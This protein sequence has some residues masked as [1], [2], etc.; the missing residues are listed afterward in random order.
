MRTVIKPFELV[1]PA[2]VDQAL[3]L[4]D[5]HKERAMIVAGGTDVVVQLVEKTLAPEIVIDI[6]SIK[7]L[8][9]I[10]EKDGAITIGALTTHTS[11]ERS[12][13]VKQK[14]PLLADAARDVGSAQIRNRGTIGGNLV[15]ASPAADTAPPLLALAAK[16][17]LLGAGGERV[18][19]IEEFFTGAR[20]SVI[21]RN[22]ILTEIQIPI[23]ANGRIGTRWLKVGRRNAFTISLVN[24]AVLMSLDRDKC[25]SVRI[26][27]GAVASTPMRAR[28]AEEFLKGR[29]L[30]EATLKEAG[31]IA[32]SETSPITDIRASAEYRREVSAAIVRRALQEA[33]TSRS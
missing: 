26:A 4:L 5:K 27:L 12:P 3:S 6:S 23:P 29:K 8:D 7:A 20:K 24:T 17:K 33:G 15:T 16:L 11:L 18:V 28:K 32:S 30:D 14:I 19:P 22:E 9:Y 2:T 13:L 25:R 31:A 21:K 10:T 1:V